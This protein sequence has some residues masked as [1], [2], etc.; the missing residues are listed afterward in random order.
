MIQ[1]CW[2]LCKIHDK[3]YIGTVNALGSWGRTVYAHVATYQRHGANAHDIR[4]AVALYAIDH[5]PVCVDED[6]ED[7]KRPTVSYEFTRKTNREVDYVKQLSYTSTH[8]ASNHVASPHAVESRYYENISKAVNVLVNVADERE[9]RADDI[10]TVR[11]A[12]VAHYPR[13]SE[14][15]ISSSR[16]PR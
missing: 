3:H 15:A 11:F 8:S 10:E 12:I 1:L 9:A 5:L 14:S 4:G 13:V 7:V 2:V 16:F 6:D